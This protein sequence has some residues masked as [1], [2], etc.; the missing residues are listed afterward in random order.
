MADRM[1]TC[2]TCRFWNGPAGECR[3]HAPVHAD[4]SYIN[5]NWPE[6]GRVAE[7]LTEW[8]QALGSDW[9][10]DYENRWPTGG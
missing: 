3:R 10:G 2:G 4:R 7:Y 1:D 8:P 5:P 6:R 9:C